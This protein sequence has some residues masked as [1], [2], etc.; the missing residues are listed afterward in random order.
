MITWA[1]VVLVDPTL[2]AVPVPAQNAILTDTA[3]Q[4]SAETWE[5]KYDLAHKYL[6]AHCGVLYLRGQAVHRGLS[7][8]K[9]R[10]CRTSVQRARKPH[11][12][13]WPRLS[14]V[15][16]FPTALRGC[17]SARLPLWCSGPYAI[18]ADV[19]SAG[20]QPIFGHTHL[21]ESDLRNSSNRSSADLVSRSAC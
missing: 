19:L 20:W 21:T 10:R 13:P 17:P 3:L 15:R 16:E 7:R 8:V 5:T 4:L 1:D 14:G 6:A 2:S 12:L 18:S 9:S 11:R